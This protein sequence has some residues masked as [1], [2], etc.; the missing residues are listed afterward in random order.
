MKDSVHPRPG[1]KKKARKRS[2]TPTKLN[3]GTELELSSSDDAEKDIVSV[4]ED[5]TS[6]AQLVEADIHVMP[7]KD[8][9]KM[10]SEKTGKEETIYITMKNMSLYHHLNAGKA[11]RLNTTLHSKIWTNLQTNGKWYKAGWRKV[12]S[13]VDEKIVMK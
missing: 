1:V 3:M 12:S 11:R 7:Q 6:P 10:R 4:D 13:Q 5:N 2:K 8:A 9:V